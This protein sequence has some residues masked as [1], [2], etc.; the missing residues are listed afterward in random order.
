MTNVDPS[1]WPPHTDHADPAWEPDRPVL[2]GS[3]GGAGARSVDRD[4]WLWPL[5]PEGTLQVACERL[6][7]GIE[8]SVQEW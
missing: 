4:C 3:G 6:D 8:M 1:P 5:P 7:Q 2:L